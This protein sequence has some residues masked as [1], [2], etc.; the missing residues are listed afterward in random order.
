MGLYERCGLLSANA[1]NPEQVQGSNTKCECKN[2]SA[3]IAECL[4]RSQLSPDM[5]RAADGAHTEL[6]QSMKK[7]ELLFTM[8]YIQFLCG[9]Y[10]LTNKLM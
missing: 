5:C 1:H 8:G 10:F 4:A 6:A 2:W 3:F 9:Y 7:T